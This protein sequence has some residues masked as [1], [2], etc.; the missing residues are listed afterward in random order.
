[1]LGLEEFWDT[2]IDIWHFTVH[3]N[4]QLW[5]INPGGGGPGLTFQIV[6]ELS[7]MKCQS[8]GGEDWHF[9][10]G[11]DCQ[12]YPTISVRSTGLQLAWIKIR[13]K[14]HYIQRNEFEWKLKVYSDGQTILTCIQ[15]SFCGWHKDCFSYS[16]LHVKLIPWTFG[17]AGWPRSG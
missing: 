17:K 5:N 9:T 7:V 10:V 6:H 4:C 2:W 8:W 12:S 3:V 15:P 11:V 14:I 1:M 16:C 13:L